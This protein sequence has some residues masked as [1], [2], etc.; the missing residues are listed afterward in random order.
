MSIRLADISDLEFILPIYAYAREQ[1]RQNGNPDQWG[2]DW[3]SAERVSMDIQCRQLYVIEQNGQIDGIFAFIIGEEPTYQSI[4]GSW[5]NSLPYGTIHRIAAREGGKAVFKQCLSYC[6]TLIST[7]RIDTHSRN[8]IMQ[9]LLSQ[10]GFQPC[11]TIYVEDGT[12][13]I[14]YQKTIEWGCCIK[15]NLYKIL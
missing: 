13:R 8:T 3:P 11:G 12:P 9:T 4:E 15:K 7:I 1:M 6:E 10:N 2:T 14:A 5:Q